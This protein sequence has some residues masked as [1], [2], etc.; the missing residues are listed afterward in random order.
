MR[1]SEE[2]SPQLPPKPVLPPRPNINQ[3][4]KQNDNEIELENNEEIE[5][6]IPPV[7]PSLPSLASI[8]IEKKAEVLEQPSLPPQE[9][10]EGLKLPKPSISSIIKP[11]PSVI[12]PDALY[13]EESGKYFD[14]ATGYEINTSNG[15]LIVPDLEENT[16][17]PQPQLPPDPRKLDV[18]TSLPVPID[19]YSMVEKV[20]II[21]DIPE[22]VEFEDWT[23]DES[24]DTS[25]GLGADKDEDAALRPKRTNGLTIKD[26]DIIM[27]RFMARYRYAYTD[28]LARLTNKTKAAVKTR[29][30]KLAKE[31][32]IRKEVITAG[33]EIWL[34]RKAGNIIVDIDFPEIKKGSVSFITVAHTI[35]LANLGVELEMLAGGKNIL[36]EEDFPRFNRYPLGMRYGYSE[37]SQIGEMTVTEREI[38]RGNRLF[39]GNKTTEDMRFLVEAAISNADAPELEEGNEGLFVVYGKGKD[40]E[41]VPDLV[42]ARKRN[43]SFGVEHIAIELEL[44]VKNITE[45]KRILRW[46]KEHGMMFKKVYY[47]TH[48]R[49]I[50][51]NITRIAKELNMEDYVKIRKYIPTNGKQPFWG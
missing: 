44:T 25:F 50:A 42:I 40:G 45:W 22:N 39:R 36:G 15:L 14:M 27:M 4:S 41:H 24:T 29:L 20:E 11:K 46:Y 13:D 19:S 10:L 23:D 31:G 34:T 26:D 32:L 12:P 30:N 2:T 37:P 33:Q 3:S 47:F 16:I 43:D 1:M 5:L 48:S 9:P 17:L 51:D 6:T 38:R 18:D 21:D 8:G 28:Q 7:F 49:R 35:G